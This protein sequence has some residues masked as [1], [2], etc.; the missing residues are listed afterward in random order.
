MEIVDCSAK[1][2]A[3]KE[4]KHVYV[5]TTI[6]NILILL[7]NNRICVYIYFI[8]STEYNS[9]FKYILARRSSAYFHYNNLY[10]FSKLLTN[11]K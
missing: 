1:C 8:I 10:I 11:K 9:N 6:W 4:N 2:K 7:L 3:N 5:T